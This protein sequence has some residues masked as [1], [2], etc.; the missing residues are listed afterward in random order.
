MHFRVHSTYK[1]KSRVT[2]WPQHDRA[3]V[4]RGEIILWV[5]EEAIKAWG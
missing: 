5:S 4:R 3:L 1:T 2:N